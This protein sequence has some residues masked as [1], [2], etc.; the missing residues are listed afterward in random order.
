MTTRSSTAQNVVDILNNVFAMFDEIIEEYQFEK[1]RTIGY[2]SVHF[3]HII[4]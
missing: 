4:V 2:V 1:I 3:I